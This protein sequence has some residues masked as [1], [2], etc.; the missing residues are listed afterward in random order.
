MGAINEFGYTGKLQHTLHDMARRGVFSPR[1]WKRS[2]VEDPR[3]CHSDA[4]VPKL[5]RGV[6]A[7]GPQ[8][9]VGVG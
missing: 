3:L 1:V 6:Q 2:R 5:H 7:H 4:K 8:D 9:R